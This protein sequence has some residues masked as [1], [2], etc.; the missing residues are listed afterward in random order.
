M[1]KRPR[2]HDS[3][4]HIAKIPATSGVPS[5]VKQQLRSVKRML[6]RPNLPQDVKL[7]QEKRLAMLEAQLSN[8]HRSKK[9]HKYQK[10]YKMLKF[11]EHQKILRRLS[12]AEHT[13]EKCK[14]DLDRQ[15]LDAELEQ[16]QADLDYVTNYPADRKYVALYPH[17]DANPQATEKKRQ[18]IRDLIVERQKQQALAPAPAAQADASSSS[19]S[20]DNTEE[21]PDD[22][23]I[24]V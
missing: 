17:E 16:L 3:K 9:E 5:G 8:Q 2:T 12:K 14:T 10:K 22:F 1:P 7:A 18:A 15:K 20:D 13:L 23:L 4:D 6:A 21:E 24:P 11:L 19:E